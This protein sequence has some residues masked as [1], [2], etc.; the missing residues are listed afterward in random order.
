MQ[1]ITQSAVE[2]L[3]CVKC[4]TQY[5]PKGLW[6]LCEKCGGLLDPKYNL[7]LA[8]ESNYPNRKQT[9]NQT[10][11]WRWLTFLPITSPTDL[12]TAGEGETPLHPAKNLSKQLKINKLWIKDETKNPTGCFKDRGAVITATKLHQHHVSDT[13]IAS[14]GNASISLALYTQLAGIRC[15]AYVPHTI[16]QTKKQLLQA[17]GAE[18]KVIQGTLADAGKTAS[19]EAIQKGWY[20]ASTFITP[21]RHDGKGTMAWEMLE[22]LDWQAPDAVVYPV[23]GGVGLVG[24]WKAFKYA[25]ELGWSD[26]TPRMIGIQ[27]E[28]CAP[29]VRAFEQGREDVE[30]WPHPSTIATGLLVPRPLGGAITL[31][32]IRESKGFALAVSEESIRHSIREVLQEEGFFLEPSAAAAFA[33]LPKLR[34]AGVL[35]ASDETVVTATG[36]GLKTPEHLV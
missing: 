6:S 32:A 31:H 34:E 24:M 10:G 9:P 28:G 33:A 7:T 19:E 14:E 16:S 35:D 25:K 21:Y 30:A 22:Q 18:M 27:P 29:V 23:G 3:E 4:G 1:R 11:I 8:N 36:S 17:L 13:I 12:L 15:H 26:K 5:P 2:S 20:N